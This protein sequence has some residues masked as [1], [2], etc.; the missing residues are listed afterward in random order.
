VI[1]SEEHKHKGI[2]KIEGVTRY[3]VN[4]IEGITLY[5]HI[6]K[7]N[8]EK[9]PIL[10]MMPGQPRNA[11]KIIKNVIDI[12]DEKGFIVVT[13]EFNAEEFPIHKYNYLN[14]VDETKKVINNDRETWTLKL[15]P[16]IV[17]EYRKK[18]G[19]IE[20]DCYMYGFSAGAQVLWN[21]LLHAT[22]DEISW[23]KGAFPFS[24]GRYPYP[25]ADLRFP[26]GTGGIESWDEEKLKRLL[27][28][29]IIMGVGSD[30]VKQ[31]NHFS[32]ENPNF[33]TGDTRVERAD[34][35]Y[36]FCE[37]KARK[38]GL[39]DKFKLNWENIIVFGIGHDNTQKVGEDGKIQRYGMARYIANIFP[40]LI[41]ERREN[42][43]DNSQDRA[44]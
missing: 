37:E 2:E 18:E 5:S 3:R 27:E 29:K 23:L 34:Y 14:I 40:I 15:I 38:F 11:K 25:K 24:A 10:F 43:Q 12:S 44:N 13:F 22:D 32:K 42:L 19:L 21:F 20:N 1:Y 8:R 31:D 17:E 35:F 30:D 41:Q 9:A 26:Y 6:P 39:E 7:W 16:Q 33:K 28:M 4:G 36:H